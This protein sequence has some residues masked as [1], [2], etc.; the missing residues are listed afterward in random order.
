MLMQ[1]NNIKAK[2]RR[3]YRITTRSKHHL[4]SRNL[5]HRDF[6]LAILPDRLYTAD[7][8]YVPT[9][10][11][12]L[13][14]AT[15]MDLF[16]SKIVGVAMPNNIQQALFCDALQ[17]AITRRQPKPGLLLHSDRGSQYCSSD[18]RDILQAQGFI[19]SMSRKG[20]CWDNAP[21]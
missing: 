16:S 12:R 8:T 18:Y 9:Q 15:V 2:R 3:G 14:V 10:E 4:A 5:L 7:I 17:Q 1:A 13:Y 19:Q 20:N 11:G 21:G 6:D